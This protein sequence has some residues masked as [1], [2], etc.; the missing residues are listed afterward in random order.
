MFDIRIM[1]D[2]RRIWPLT[3]IL[4]SKTIRY[5]RG[6]FCKISF[7]R[8]IRFFLFSLYS[9]FF[10]HFFNQK[11]LKRGYFAA[12]P[13]K[14]AIFF[15]FATPPQEVPKPAPPPI[16]WPLPPCV[17]PHA[18]LC[19]QRIFLM[20][21][22]LASFIVAFQQ[23]ICGQRYAK[24]SDCYPPPPPPPRLR[25]INPPGKFLMNCYIPQVKYFAAKGNIFF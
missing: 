7:D 6:I 21:M 9:T 13:P 14:A 17:G 10:R 11:H 12:L 19:G 24:V 8:R 2:I 15:A 18:P 20:Q 4:C 25:K 3:K 16:Y 23:D 1:F 5:K 22:R